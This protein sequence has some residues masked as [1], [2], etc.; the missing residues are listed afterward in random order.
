MEED[1]S[2]ELSQWLSTYGLLTAERIFERIHFALTQDELLST[3]RN[4]QGVCHQLLRVPLKNVFNGI[5][6]QQA[7]DYLVYAQKLFIE[8]LLS[9]EGNREESHDESIS[10]SDTREALEVAR[11]SLIDMEKAFAQREDAHAHLIAKSQASLIKLSKDLQK[12]SQQVVKKM[13][14][15]SKPHDVTGDDLQ[16]AVRYFLIHSSGE[17]TQDLLEVPELFWVD[18]ASTWPVELID[19]LRQKLPE[20]LRPLADFIPSIHQTL[21]PYIEQ[22]DDLEIEFCQ[23]RRQFYALIVEVTELIKSLPD[24]HLNAEQETKN[25]ESLYFDAQLGEAGVY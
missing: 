24:Y 25:R 3:V 10:G 23:D 4:P 2:K 18:V 19:E 11:L 22:A 7:R 16:H 21:A 9:P 6:F 17:L 8:Y 15:I 20:L 13:T 5:I 12:K 14:R 1:K